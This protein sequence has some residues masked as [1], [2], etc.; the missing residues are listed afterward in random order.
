MTFSVISVTFSSQWS[1]IPSISPWISC[2][3]V[4]TVGRTCTLATSG[5]SMG[6]PIWERSRMYISSIPTTFET[7]SVAICVESRL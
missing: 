4:P 5:W 7:Q 1:I 2:I 3:F 6:C